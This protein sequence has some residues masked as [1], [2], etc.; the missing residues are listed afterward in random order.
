MSTFPA[1]WALCGGW[2][3]DTWLGHPTRNHGDVDIS[4]F[5]D[6]QCALFEHLSPDWQLIAHD[7]N[8]PD[9]TTDPWT[10]RQLDLP[11]HVHARRPGAGRPLGEA[12]NP[13]EDGFG[14]DIELGERA[15]ER[16]VLSREPYVTVP[17]STSVAMSPWRIPTLTP[18]VLPH[19]W[20]R[21]LGPS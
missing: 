20:L 14:L 15:G 6:D 17:L 11:A 3:I 5:H 12:L 16:W 7:P 2:A 13:A 4:V 1:P 19:P 18:E 8:V 21:Q 10:G 9:A